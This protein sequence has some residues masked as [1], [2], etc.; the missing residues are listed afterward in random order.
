[1]TKDVGTHVVDPELILGFFLGF[2]SSLPA[3]PSSSAEQSLLIFATVPGELAVRIFPLSSD[4][5]AVLKANN[6]FK[7]TLDSATDRELLSDFKGLNLM[8]RTVY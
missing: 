2:A 8:V 3:P 5:L 6:R 7:N 1:L 4:Q